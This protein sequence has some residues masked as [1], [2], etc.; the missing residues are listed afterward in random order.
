MAKHLINFA[1][2]NQSN[3]GFRVSSPFTDG[4]SA[5][6]FVAI[7]RYLA[8]IGPVLFSKPSVASMRGFSAPEFLVFSIR[9]SLAVWFGR[10]LVDR[11]TRHAFLARGFGHDRLVC[12]PTRGL[13]PCFHILT[14]LS[15]FLLPPA[16]SGVHGVLVRCHSSQG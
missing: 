4:H 8:C 9:P 6:E 3:P 14:L 1:R 15:W 13:A 5:T 16:P 2:D 10:K 12:L 11:I 7:G